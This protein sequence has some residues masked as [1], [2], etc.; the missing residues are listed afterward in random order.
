[1]EPWCTVGIINWCSHFGQQYGGCAKKLKIELPYD[2]AR[3]HRDIYLEKTNTTSKKY[4]H[5]VVHCSIICNSQDK[6]AT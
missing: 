3:A 6:K 1:M 4:M 2:P 5:A